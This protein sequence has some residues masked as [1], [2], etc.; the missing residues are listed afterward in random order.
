MNFQVIERDGSLLLAAPEL[1]EHITPSWF[2]LNWWRAQGQQVRSAPGRGESYFLS[3]QQWS[4]VWR[5]YRRGGLIA[6]LSPD[7]YLWSGLA[8]TRACAEFSLTQQLLDRGLPVPRPLA[9]RVVRDGLYYRADLMTERLAGAGSLADV[10]AA[11]KPLPW[12]QV[13]ATIARFHRAGLD[14]VDLN[15]RNIL[16]DDR[17]RVF[18]IDFDRCRL[19]RPARSWQ[20]SNLARLRRSLRKLFPALDREDDWQLLLQGYGSD[21]A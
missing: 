17:G 20:Q 14:H 1:V 13:G 9:G 4:L 10:L 11:G 5:H 21:V 3:Y 12:A 8:R 2:D 7:R 15:L 19:R 18:L 6:R 16:L